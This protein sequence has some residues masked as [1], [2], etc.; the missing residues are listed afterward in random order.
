MHTSV[1]TLSVSAHSDQVNFLWGQPPVQQDK[2]HEITTSR[3]LLGLIP[4]PYSGGIEFN[5][6]ELR[7]AGS[8]AFE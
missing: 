6:S 1:Q 8:T 3:N 4:V 5:A 7:I 2:R